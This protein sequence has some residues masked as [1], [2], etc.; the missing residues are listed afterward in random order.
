MKRYEAANEPPIKNWVIC[1]V[2]N[3]FFKK[4]GKS[5]VED[6]E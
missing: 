2:V 6:N 4:A 5:F 3:C 1:N